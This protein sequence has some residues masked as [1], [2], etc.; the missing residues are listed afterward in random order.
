MKLPTSTIDPSDASNNV[1]K[2]VVAL[3]NDD[4]VEGQTEAPE[5]IEKYLGA[6][7]HVTGKWNIRDVYG[8]PVGW[9]Y[10]DSEIIILEELPSN[11]QTD[12]EADK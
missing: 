4:D 11:R 9:G 3:K 1:W 8:A 5:G 6:R 2:Y 10:A 7:A 12:M